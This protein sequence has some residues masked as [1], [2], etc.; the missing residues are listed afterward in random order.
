MSQLT[1]RR[2]F[3]TM[4]LAEIPVG[5]WAESNVVR[6]V[7]VC[8][9]S[10]NSNKENWEKLKLGRMVKV[11]KRYN[12][13]K[14]LKLLYWK[15]W[16]VLVVRANYEISMWTHCFSTVTKETQQGVNTGSEY[17]GKI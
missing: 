9:F 1:V 11:K 8:M 10:V 16:N 17:G 3:V 14:L 2:Y 15:Q 13:E 5:A 12:V 6:G 4:L 7:C